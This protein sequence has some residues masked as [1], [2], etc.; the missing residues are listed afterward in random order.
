MVGALS[1]LNQV[2]IIT[3]KLVD[4]TSGREKNIDQHQTLHEHHVFTSQ[5]QQLQ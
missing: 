5:T 2:L 1:F 4:G 3:I